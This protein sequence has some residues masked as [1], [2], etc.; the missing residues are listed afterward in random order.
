MKVKY[1]P[2]TKRKVLS[3]FTM[4][5]K[6][7]F[8]IVRSDPKKERWRITKF[9]ASFLFVIQLNWGLVSFQFVLEGWAQYVILQIFQTKIIGVI[10]IYIAWTSLE[11]A[12][13]W[14]LLEQM[15]IVASDWIF[16]WDFNMVEQISNSQSKG[17]NITSIHLL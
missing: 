16:V 11:K 5:W 12:Q 1:F 14:K 15:D 7:I 17:H 10:N 6:G 13:M 3:I 8:T 9:L 4:L 2:Y